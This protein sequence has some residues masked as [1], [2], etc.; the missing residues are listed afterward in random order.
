MDKEAK[1]SA[2]LALYSVPAPV[3]A[4]APAPVWACRDIQEIK[5][6][7]PLGPVSFQNRISHRYKALVKFQ[8]WLAEGQQ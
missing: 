5:S 7:T 8:Q 4:P 1:V 3:A 6:L 2:F